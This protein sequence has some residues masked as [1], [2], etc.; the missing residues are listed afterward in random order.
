MKII[1]ALLS[2]DFPQDSDQSMAISEPQIDNT[3]GHGATGYNANIHYRGM[4]VMMKPST[5]LAL[6][7]PLDREHSASLEAL[8]KRG[9][10]IGSPFLTI[11]IPDGW[12]E[13]DFSEP[14]AVVIGHEGRN[15]SKAIMKL[16]GDK[17]IEVHI[18]AGGE[19]YE[20][21]NRHM[22]DEVMDHLNAGM[23]AE[24]THD[25]VKG[26]LFQIKK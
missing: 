4:R 19:R 15:R 2:E 1:E 14:Y 5:F 3:M 23:I 9:E 12:R 21:R 22:N 17:P 13:D 6:A 11:Q 7:A 20:W 8:I 26:P 10:A 16:F 18:V 24:R 25:L